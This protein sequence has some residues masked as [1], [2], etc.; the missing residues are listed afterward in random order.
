MH[1]CRANNSEQWNLCMHLQILT[2]F[3]LFHIVGSLM[4]PLMH[5][6]MG[7]LNCVTLIIFWSPQLHSF[8]VCD[9]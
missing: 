6:Q 3:T 2:V 7:V 4:M 1:A 9:T 5:I 8:C